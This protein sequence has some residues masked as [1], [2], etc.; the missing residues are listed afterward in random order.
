LENSNNMGFI[1]SLAQ[2]LPYNLEAE[3]SV[4]GAVL[5][6]ND[7]VAQV[8]DILKPE[9]FYRRQHKE[10]F[11]VIMRMF[12]SSE[13]IDFITVLE[14]V[15]R[16]E[17]FPTESD[18]KIY[19]SQLVQVVPPVKDISAYARIIK[20]KYCLRSLVSTFEQVIAA[21]RE[22]NTDPNMLMDMAEQGIYDIRQGKDSSGF[23]HVRDV[24]TLTYDRLQKIS[25]EESEQYRAIPTGFPRLDDVIMGLNKSDLIILAARPGMGK[26]AFALNLACNVAKAGK[27]VAVFSLE[28]SNEQLV[29]RLIASEGLVSSEHLHTGK[30][31]DDEW[32]KMAVAA[33]KLSPM[34][35]YLDDTAGIHIGEMK[36]K[37]RRLKDVSLVVI[38]YLQLMTGGDGTRRNENRVQEVSDMTRSLKIMA[39]EFNIPIIVLSQ[40][41]RG[42]ESR[43]D[44][45]PMLSDLRESGSIEQ[46]ADIVM[47][48]YREAYYKKDDPNVSQ[49]TAECIVAK[50][51]HGSVGTVML[52]WDG[53]HTKFN[54]YESRQDDF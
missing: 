2:E 25:G 48:L 21:S 16:E 23:T 49:G 7:C 11:S 45:R 39:K 28:M 52:G 17:I 53:E 46:D 18:A 37:L 47:M 20:E 31:A 32:G 44:R 43:S 41:S 10:I 33:Q 38:D 36:A 19:L 51:R 42:P 22:G 14:K 4:L 29:E 34:P 24:I 54:S 15:Y 30:I 8:L 12:I 50:N 3:Q 13:T 27:K 1:G 35:L 5:I 6:D 26:T 40:L 9:H